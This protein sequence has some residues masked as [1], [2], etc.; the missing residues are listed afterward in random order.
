MKPAYKVDKPSLFSKLGYD[1]MPHQL[2]YHNSKARF[3]IACCGRR[4]GKTSMAGHDRIAELMKPKTL[5][6]IVGPT[7]DLAMKEFRVMWEALIVELGLGKDK[8]LRSQSLET[9]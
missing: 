1:P 8:G 7:Y 6:W 2:E 3:R 5:G 4:A 9:T